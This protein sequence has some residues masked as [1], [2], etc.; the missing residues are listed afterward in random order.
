MASKLTQRETIKAILEAPTTIEERIDAY[1]LLL[2]E[3]HELRAKIDK[4]TKVLRGEIDTK[5]VRMSQLEEEIRKEATIDL[6]D[7]NGTEVVGRFY[8]VK[9][10]KAAMS[11]TINN[12]KQVAE[13]V[14][15]DEFFK[16]CTFPLGQIDNYLTPPQRE[17][18]LDVEHGGKRSFKI[19]A[20]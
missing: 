12:M 9:I 18:V 4:R 14:G 11:R 13:M 7:E 6:S 1:G 15:F 2:E 17:E 19:T 10:G 20:R 16:L 8:F 5:Q 3:V